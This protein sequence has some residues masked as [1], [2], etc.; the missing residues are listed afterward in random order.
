MSN[1]TNKDCPRCSVIDGLTFHDD[2]WHCS[3]C[4]RAFSNVHR[5]LWDKPDAT[6]PKESTEEWIDCYYP[7]LAALPERLKE[8]A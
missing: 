5:H 3:T 2:A 6:K 4:G 8:K 1:T 7:A